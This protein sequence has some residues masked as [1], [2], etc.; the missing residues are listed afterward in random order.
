M[1]S[2]LCQR[3]QAAGGALAPALE[4]RT[5]IEARSTQKNKP[6]PKAMVELLRFFSP[7]G[8]GGFMAYNDFVCSV[9][10]CAGPA[11]LGAV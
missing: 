5:R 4:V 8:G 9:P 3:R 7:G 6:Q 11:R 1:R 10:L 2:R